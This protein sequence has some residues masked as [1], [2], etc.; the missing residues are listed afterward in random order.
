MIQKLGFDSKLN[1]FY[2]DFIHF[3]FASAR[4]WVGVSWNCRSVLFGCSNTIGFLQGKHTIV[5]VQE[6]RQKA[7]RSFY[8]YETVSA[9][10]EGSWPFLLTTSLSLNRTRHS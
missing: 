10:M 1:N 7:T 8:D 5:L 3:C 4:W 9:A 6:T 2:F